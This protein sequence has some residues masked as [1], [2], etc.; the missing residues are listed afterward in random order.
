MHWRSNFFTIHK[1]K[2]GHR[3]RETLNVLLQPIAE[4]GMFSHA[5]M[6]TAMLMP[7]MVLPNTKT[8]SDQSITKT[9]ARRLDQWNSGA[10]DELFNE[11]K[12]L[13]TRLTKFNP[14]KLPDEA[15]IFNKHMTNGKI[16]SPI[17]SIT[18]DQKGGVLNLKDKIGNKTVLEVLKEKHPP[19]APADPAYMLK[20]DSPS[21]PYH[22]TIFER[23]SARSVRTAAMKT[24][25]SHGPSGIDANEWRRILSNFNSSSDDLC[26]TIAQIAQRIA[27]VKLNPDHL[28][29]YNACRLIPLDKNPG[30]RPIGVGE[31][32]R[33]IIGRCILKCISSDLKT[34]GSNV[35]LCLGQ[36]CGIEHAIHSLLTCFE[37]PTTDAV[38]LIDAKNAFNVLNREL[39]I[40]NIEEL[41]PSLSNAVTNS[42]ST[43]S[44]LSVN[45]QTL[46]SK[47]GTTQGD[48]LAMAMYGIAI[49]PLTYRIQQENMLQKW[50][51]DDG[52]A[53]G[54]ITTLLNFSMN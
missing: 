4:N 21:I 49:L 11:A 3:F 24:H 53:A 50:Y 45:H 19:A 42:Y 41:C 1:N 12:S 8:P 7:H 34:L 43:P 35:Q 20:Q 32:L 37:D 46:F 51:A 40:H 5:S 31:V 13:Q 38:L 44:L 36:K 54:D 30:V 52:T 15:K 28:T 17:R 33:R 26:K 9:I 14:H 22:P 47:E 25:G 23:I 6:M 48:P 29:A 16:S 2:V 10:F 27:S 18:D 39:A